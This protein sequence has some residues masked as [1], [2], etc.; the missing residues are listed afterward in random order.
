M[1]V[2]AARHR[3]AFAAVPG[4]AA[5]APESPL[6]AWLGGEGSVPGELR[7]IAG[8]LRGGKVATWLKTLL[9]DSF[10][11]S[12]NDLVVR[13]ASMYGG[14]QRS[15]GGLYLLDAGPDAS[16]FNYFANPTTASAAVRALLE[17]AP[18]EFRPI[19][20]LANSG[21]SSDGSR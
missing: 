20:P 8:N 16:H 4:I 2:A 1:T 9:A 21:Q 6:I 13:T 5:L 18:S 12:E 10:Y 17:E 14:A 7:V 3:D 19:G 11:M 15:G